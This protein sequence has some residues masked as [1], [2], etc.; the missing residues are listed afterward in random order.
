MKSVTVSLKA[1]QAFDSSTHMGFH[2]ARALGE[3]GSGRQAAE[4][5]MGNKG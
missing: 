2:E 4:I 5:D 1:L 3:E